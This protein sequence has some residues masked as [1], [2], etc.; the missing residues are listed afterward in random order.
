VHALTDSL[1]P[2]R[3]LCKG[4]V[5]LSEKAP[6]VNLLRLDNLPATLPWLLKQEMQLVSIPVAT[7][8]SF[9]E[10]CSLETGIEPGLFLRIEFDRNLN[11]F[12]KNNKKT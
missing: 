1:P 12:K 11:D 5:D 3:C 10:V 4:K 9:H 2:K 8:R 7:L 6:G